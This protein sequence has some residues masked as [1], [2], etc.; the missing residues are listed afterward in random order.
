VLVGTDAGLAIGDGTAP[1]SAYGFARG[2]PGDA[3]YDIVIAAGG[4]IWIR[5]DD[6]IAR[7]T[8]P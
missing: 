8:L 3:V 7:V 6:G 5:S 2:L 4:D 1:F